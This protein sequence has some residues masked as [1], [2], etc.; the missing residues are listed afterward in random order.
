HTLLHRLSGQD[1]VIVG[2]PTAGQSLLNG[3][4]L[5]GHC[6]NFLPVRSRL[7]PQT[8]GSDFLKQLKA[9]LLDVYDHQSYTYGRLVRKLA[10]PRDASRLP[11][12][13]VQFNVEKVGTGVSFDGL[14]IEVTSNP[15]A[16]VNFDLFLNI[17]E[18]DSGLVMD[19]D[20][21]T[22]LFDASTVDR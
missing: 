7:T 19:C 12:I 18:S 1:E 3:E 22:D 20:Y 16:F 21:N 8:T 4:T 14:E 5:V 13:E 6:V 11:L 17:V 15:K 9:D 10:L 2:I